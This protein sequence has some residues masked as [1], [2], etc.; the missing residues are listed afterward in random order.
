MKDSATAEHRGSVL[1]W[2]LQVCN[3]ACRAGGK[4]GVQFLSD[5]QKCVFHGPM[6][7]RTL[8]VCDFKSTLNEISACS[9]EKG[10]CSL[11]EALKVF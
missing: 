8:D 1:R 4:S 9:E 6:G 3:D 5:G 2:V 11:F 7:A 10:K